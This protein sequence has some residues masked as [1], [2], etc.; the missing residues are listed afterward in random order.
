MGDTGKRADEIIE[1]TMKEIYDDLN[2]SDAFKETD[3]D[4]EDSQE[5]EI[6]MED[7][8]SADISA[9]DGV[10]ETDRF[11]E[12]DDE[13]SLE[14]FD[15]IKDEEL[16]Y[17]ELE[18][19]DMEET[20]IVKAAK[21]KKRKKT[22][23][24]VAG[25]I[26][27]VLVLIYVGFAI[28]FSS[29]FM[30]F[31]KINGT[32]FSLKSVSQ[33]E[34]YMKQQVA[35][36]V[37]TLKESD[38]GSEKISGSDISLVYV[39][40]EQLEK[41]AKKQNNFL[42][43]TS[44]WNHPKITSEIGVEYDK[45]A[46]AKITEGL[47]CLKPENQTVSVDAHP[48]FQNDK[49]VVVPEVVGTQIDTEKFNEAVTKAINGFK[50]TLDLF[51]TGCYILPRFVSDSQEVV[52]ATDA[53]N[54]YLGANVTYDFNPATEVVDASVISQW[55]T[56]D[57]DMNVTFNEEAVRAF[58]QSLADKYDTK[59]K[60][61]TFTTATGNTVNVTGGS[62]G[63]KIDQEAE[64]NAL[65]ANIQ[66][67]ETVT[68]EPNYA[69]RAASH[70]GNDVGSTYAE[71]D[72]SNQMMYF[73]QNGQVVLQSGIVTGNPNKGNGTP[74]GVYSLAYKALDQV[75][76]GTKKPDGTYEY[77]TPVKFWMP[78]NGGIGFHDATWQSS[79][80]GSRYQTNGSHGCVNLPYD[81][82]AQ[83]YN[84]ITAGTPVVCHY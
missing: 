53:M 75:L 36:Y 40:G 15:D 82:A 37:L 12:I 62:Y 45:D 23:A 43:I 14:E 2:S 58:I 34:A 27:G 59:G 54:S 30:F 21:K 48:E 7:D 11:D 61:R 73:V 52:A 47:E 46:L 31:T 49:F 26:I 33:V 22:A 63:W 60:P 71:V 28:F 78:F 42:W 24:I 50:P 39:P 69:S 76:R 19:D 16:E 70:E 57:A 64:Y 10:L 44:L 35:D 81:V 5:E 79:F 6:D 41:L 74:Q 84:L 55:V 83:L 68:R 20:D 72:L 56:V 65:I 66:N 29:H 18:D 3:D 13:D 17:D 67:A 9:D 25:I 77:E 80:G 4:Y 32:D 38:G 51:K 8:D 1:E